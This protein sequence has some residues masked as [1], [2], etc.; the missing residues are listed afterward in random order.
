M[1][2]SLRYLYFKNWFRNKS[3]KSLLKE[4]LEKKEFRSIDGGKRF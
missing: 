1:G 2:F 3:R 4:D